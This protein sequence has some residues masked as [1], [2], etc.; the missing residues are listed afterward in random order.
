MQIPGRPRPSATPASK[1]AHQPQ[2][3]IAFSPGRRLQGHLANETCGPRCPGLAWLSA[4]T[5]HHSA[6]E[7]SRADA[8]APPVSQSRVPLPNQGTSLSSIL[9]P[10]SAGAGA[11]DGMAIGHARDP[12]AG[13]PGDRT[14]TDESSSHHGETGMEELPPSPIGEGFGIGDAPT[15]ALSSGKTENKWVVPASCGILLHT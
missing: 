4:S 5:H 8:A 15:L 10:R 6:N 3:V 7:Q 9:F 11:W 14:G 12:G 13:P 2:R 1:P